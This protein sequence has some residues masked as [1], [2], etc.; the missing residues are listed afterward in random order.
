VALAEH[1]WENHHPIHWA[2]TGPWQRTEAV[3]E[4]GPAHPDDTRRKSASTEVDQ[5]SLVAEPL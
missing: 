1:A 5:L 4:G 3:V 2:H